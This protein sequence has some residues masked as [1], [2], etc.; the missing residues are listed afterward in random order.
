MV[1]IWKGINAHPRR[2]IGLGVAGAMLV[3]AGY[4]ALTNKNSGAPDINPQNPVST[5]RLP[6]NTLQ[7]SNK[8]TEVKTTPIPTKTNSA[9]SKNTLI[10]NGNIVYPV[11]CYTYLG[12]P[13]KLGV[14][15][16]LWQAK[17][18]GMDVNGKS[19]WLRRDGTINATVIDP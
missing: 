2:A 18:L 10:V 16:P 19:Y 14:K 3:G 7:P 4:L 6:E 5:Q 13:I 9:Q 17:C 1:E 11:D 12:A 15:T 8:N